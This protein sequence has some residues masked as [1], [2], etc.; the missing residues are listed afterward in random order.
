MT[1]TLYRVMLDGGARGVVDMELPEGTAVTYDA[2]GLT[3]RFPLT[4]HDDG[5]GT[6]TVDWYPPHRVLS[7][8][9][10]TPLSKAEVL[11]HDAF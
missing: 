2:A 9:S 10:T 3:L 6:E 1:G 11:A 5:S 4:V 8:V 7:V